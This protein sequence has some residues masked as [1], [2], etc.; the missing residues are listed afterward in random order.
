MASKAGP[1]FA[2]GYL[3]RGLATG[4]F[5]NDGFIDA[6]FIDLN[7]RPVLL[8]N[9]SAGTN[10]WLGLRLVG[11]QSNRD[12]IGAR[13]SLRLANR[14]LTR[15][16]TGGSSFLAT[17]DQRL[18]FGLGQDTG[19][20]EIEIVWPSGVVQKLTTLARDR[21]HD[22]VEPTKKEAARLASS[23]GNSGQL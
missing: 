1:V 3:G 10:H 16:V 4:D 20:M 18:V 7:A 15:W 14:K 17:H 11:M 2:Q 12:A 23:P 6:A 5:D 9:E 22:I 21:Y 19:A 13:V 8:H